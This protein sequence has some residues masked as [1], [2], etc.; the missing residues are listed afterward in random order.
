MGGFTKGP[1][2]AVP[3][4]LSPAGYHVG[5]RTPEVVDAEGRVVAT[6]RRFAA[7]IRQCDVAEANAKLMAAAP[8]LYEALKHMDALFDDEGNF[9]EEFQDQA[10][11]ALEK[12]NTALQGVEQ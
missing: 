11:V 5:G 1:W 9:R 2:K 10:S 4:R 6:A 7:P 3:E 12:M 8:A